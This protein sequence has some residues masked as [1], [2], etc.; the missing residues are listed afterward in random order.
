MKTD[1]KELSNAM[2]RNA[3]PCNPIPFSNGI[4]Q[5]CTKNGSDYIQTDEAKRILYVLLCQ[6]YGQIFN[7]NGFDEF[8]RLRKTV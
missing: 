6:A 1:L 2:F 7:L 4:T 8:N 5:G 3:L